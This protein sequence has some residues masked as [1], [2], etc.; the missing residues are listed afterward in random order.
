MNKMIFKW[1][2]ALLILTGCSAANSLF[3]SNIRDLKTLEKSTFLYSLP[4]T[5]INVEVEF[6]K[7]TF[8]PGPYHEYA[9]KYLGIEG[10]SHEL[11][12]SWKIKKITVFSSSEPDPDFFYSVNLEDESVKFNEELDQLSQSGLI[13]LPGRF[14]MNG[15]VEAEISIPEEN[16]IYYKDLSVKRNMVLEKETSYKRVFRDS[17]YVQIPFE[18]ESQVQKSPELRAEEAANFIIKLRKRRFRLLTGQ[19]EG[20]APDAAIGTAIDELNWIE[21]EYLT[22]FTGKTIYESETRH[23][24]Y[25]P[26]SDRITDQQVLFKISDHEGIFDSTSTEGRP[27]V[28]EIECLDLTRHLKE[29][30]SSEAPNT[31]YYRQPDLARITISLEDTRLFENQLT[32]YQY[33]PVVSQQIAHK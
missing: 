14:I 26:V 17:M 32:V 18:T 21:Q 4:R 16:E 31:L 3:I 27:V 19:S 5:V 13:I 10:V 2:P 23:F 1:I 30:R 24:R 7:S 22:L 8:I 33:G 28:L 29:I 25:I 6:R 15:P 11:T 12:E 9:G 20:E